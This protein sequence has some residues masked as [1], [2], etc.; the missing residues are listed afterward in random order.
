MNEKEV[1]QNWAAFWM[2]FK[3]KKQKKEVGAVART[4]N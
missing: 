2:T 3:I 1:G 4:D